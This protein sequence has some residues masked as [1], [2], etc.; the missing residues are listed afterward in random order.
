MQRDEQRR[1][2]GVA[3]L[4]DGDDDVLGPLA[5]AARRAHVSPARIARTEVWCGISQSMSPRAS[6]AR[7]GCSSISGGPSCHRDLVD[8]ARARE[9]HRARVVQRR[10][11]EAQPAVLGERREAGEQ[12]AVVIRRARGRRSPPRRHRRASATR[13]AG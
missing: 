1:R 5:D 4:V 10:Q 11:A 12:D 9:H 7:R 6:P 3:V 2:R 8:L 13:A